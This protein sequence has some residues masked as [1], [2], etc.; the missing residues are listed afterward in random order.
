MSSKA[1]E[2]I[3]VQETQQLVPVNLNAL[4]LSGAP[5]E[6][7]REAG[8]AAQALKDVISKKKNP[9]IFNG[10]QYLEFEDWQTI[11][12]FYGITAKVISSNFVEFGDVQGFEARACAFHV[13]SGKEISCADSMCLNDEK[14]WTRKPL[15]QLKSMAQTR[16]CVKALRN[17]LS[18]VAVLGG[19]KP[20]PAEE[21]QEVFSQ[22]TEL[23]KPERK[24]QRMEESKEEKKPYWTSEYDGKKYL[25]AKVGTLSVDLLES[26]GMKR[27]KPKDG[28][29][30]ENFFCT[31]SEGAEESLCKAL[32]G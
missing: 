7:L 14:N 29:P 31:Y 9:V 28:K 20:T 17:V 18:W 4:D 2:I 8:R 32:E 23:K 26:L 22:K 1:L 3:D 15:F 27:G 16:A 13:A 25:W 5:D 12:R 6:V 10:E 21:M 19:Y 30:S 11:G 24:S